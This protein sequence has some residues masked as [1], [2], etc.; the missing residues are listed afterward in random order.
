[1]C[2]QANVK[3]KPVWTF[4]CG[5]S[6]TCCSVWNSGCCTRCAGGH[7][8]PSFLLME[9]ESASQE[10]SGSFLSFLWSQ[11]CSNGGEPPHASRLL[12]TAVRAV[13]NVPPLCLC[14]QAASLLLR[15]CKII[16]TARRLLKHLQ[17]L[18]VHQRLNPGRC[19]SLTL[20]YS[21]TE[22]RFWAGVYVIQK[23]VEHQ[24]WVLLWIQ[25][26]ANGCKL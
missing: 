18:N 6:F 25:E 3:S 1:M 9:S 5:C 24:C 8:W 14:T 11:Q 2:A 13:R 7:K 16:Q 23:T 4:S 20:S 21:N 12:T 26:A 10:T 17:F 15:F 22:K 19:D